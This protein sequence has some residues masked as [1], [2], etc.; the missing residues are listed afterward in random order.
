MTAII[1]EIMKL[2]PDSKKISDTSFEGA[3]IILY[4]KDS[5][6]FLNNQGMIKNIVDNIKKRVELRPDPAITMDIEKAEKKIREIIPKE[7]EIGSILFDPQRSR[8]IIEVE[9]PGLAIG[10]EGDVLRE[11]RKQCLWVPVVRRTP[12]LRSKIIE[13]IRAVM[14]QHSDERRKFLDKVGHRIYDGW[15]RGK[16]EEWVRLT[17]L[18]GARQVG[19]SCLFLQTPETR[20]LLDCGVN[21]AAQGQ[22]AY[23]YLDAPEFKL[24]DLDA[25]I[26]SHAH[27]DHSGVVP[28]LFRMGY[29]GP[30]YCTAP[31]R[32]ISALLALDFISVAFKQAKSGIFDVNDV[33]EM[34]KHT[35]C[36]DYG[37]VT[38]ITPDLRITFSNAGH[39]I[40]SSL[41]HLHVGNGLTNLLYSLD[42]KTPVTVID[43]DD[44]T[45][46]KPI[47]QVVDDVFEE[48]PDLVQ[49]KD[50][51]EEIPNVTG[52]K[53]VVFNPETYKTEIH[54][55]TSLIRHLIHE[56]IY[57]IKTATGRKAVV[58]KSHSL[59]TVLNGEVL[60]IK[61]SDLKAGD[62][63][64]GPK[65]LPQSTKR[66]V[67][68]LLP[69]QGKLRI[70]IN[71]E[72]LVQEIIFKHA[73]DFFKL[74]KNDQTQI[75]SWLT[76]HYQHALCRGDIAKKYNVHPRRI[77]RAFATLGVIDHPW[78]KHSLP[79][80]FAITPAFARLLGY[81]ISE[82]WS[83][84]RDQTI[85]ITNYNS[86]ILEDCRQIV[87]EVF[88]IESDL[89]DKD[90]VILINSKQIKYLFG[91]VLKCGKNAYTKRA[92]KEI[93]MS[94]KE[95][96]RN[97]LHGYFSGDGGIRI[98]PES[99]EISAGSK[100]PLL[101]QDI[102][103]MLLQFDIVP[104]LQYNTYSDMY[105]SY[106]YNAEKIQHFLN[107]INIQNGARERL[108]SVLPIIHSKASFDQRIPISAL[109][110]KSQNVLNKS[111]YQDAKS[112]GINV[113]KRKF[114]I[115]EKIVDSDF[116]FDQVVSITPTQ[117]TG[118][119]VY[120]FKID[121]YENFLGGEGFLFLH[122]TGD[123]KCIRTRLLDPAETRFPRIET[124]MLESTYGG[125]DNVLKSRH[126]AE[127]N[128]IQVTKETLE[129]GGKV[130]IPVLGVGRAQELILVMNEA[131]NTGKVPHCPIYAQGMVWDVTAIHTAY[132]DFL[133]RDV[134]KAIF[135]QAENPFLS[136][137][138]RRVGSKKEQD[139]VIKQ[140]VP[141][142]IIATSGMLTGGPSVEYFKQLCDNPR[143]TL[144]FV[145]Y[146]GEGTLGR[147]IQ[148]GERRIVL[149]DNE[150]PEEL[151]VRMRVHIESSLSGH[152]GRSE[153]MRYVH[154]LQPRP[155]KIIVNHGESSRCLD[156][157]S[158]IHKQ[159][160]IETFAPKNLETIRI[161]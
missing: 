160:R 130:L 118:K 133:G 119:Y 30:V 72:K 155:K 161:R 68:D 134:R 61:V 122:N 70:H 76:D 94:D 29:Q 91:G 69:Y 58:T 121:G 28:F 124:V 64:I 128:V 54:R 157:A 3:N 65:S 75:I 153:L 154:N 15:M 101:I 139:E 17:Y 126:E 140:N 59:F 120:D 24:E 32:D 52:L 51:W 66:P 138:L 14:Y 147:R 46:F 78:V 90:G 109:S 127:E 33:K 85:G 4:T 6:F 87:Q 146:V 95:I 19:R 108:A 150:R 40:G 137:N 50:G 49:R 158:S 45:S 156:L 129:N 13:N 1:D 81:Y 98:R 82:G 43:S 125:K 21:V 80:K 92:P 107:E 123:L 12:P 67:I 106:I 99:R 144:L 116:M 132:P 5:D 145:S 41:V 113:L 89:R 35:I 149:T 142:I 103:F 10:R 84:K 97:F 55:I 148:E 83:S 114:N 135:H 39:I 88:G 74:E 27:L 31:T 57:E 111:P 86:E 105:N 110:E 42:A 26:I 38:D 141:C 23:P 63:I 53:T 2:V 159:N 151:N 9:K 96:M 48:Y 104:T 73:K 136:E 131:M 11:V 16:K 37:E 22:D 34:V 47:G 36:L 20:V 8:V 115:H 79:H 25:V 143:N 44:N 152:A 100:N 77:R 112:C 60:A 71:D 18:G 56:D 7:A 102:M 93:L 117:P 62:F